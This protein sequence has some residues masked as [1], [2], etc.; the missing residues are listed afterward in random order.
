MSNRHKNWRE[1][2]HYEGNLVIEQMALRAPVWYCHVIGIAHFRAVRSNIVDVKVTYRLRKAKK[3]W[4]QKVLRIA[5]AEVVKY[6]I[7]KVSGVDVHLVPIAHMRE[8]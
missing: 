6:P 5:S 7:Q 1:G 4:N 8:I 3:D 2:I